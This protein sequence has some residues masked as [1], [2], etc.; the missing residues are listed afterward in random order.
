MAVRSALIWIGLALVIAVPLGVAATS[1][2]LAWR[3]PVYIASGF[4]GVVALALV[5]VQ[6]LL[7]AGYL[8]GVS[9][10]HGRRVHRWIGFGLVAMVLAHVG[11]LWLTSPPDVIDALLFDSPT[12]FSVWGVTAMWAVFLTALLVAMRNRLHIG[13][14][15]W[16][17]GHTALAVVIVLGSVV[18]ALLVEGA[19]GPASKAAL[20][21]LV[22]LSTAR[23]VLDLRAWTL[24]YRKKQGLR[25]P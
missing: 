9:M 13:P 15:P 7:A 4:A 22:L 5:L 19:M 25:G 1:P 18:H 8:P 3:D 11:G 6:P 14:R 12:P 10:T 21:A 17:M 20:C 2:L 23:A 24:F 16:R